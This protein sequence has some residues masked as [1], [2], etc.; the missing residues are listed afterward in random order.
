MECRNVK[1]KIYKIVMDAQEPEKEW[2]CDVL[3][4]QA[5]N[6]LGTQ[7]RAYVAVLTRELIAEGRLN[8]EVASDNTMTQVFPPKSR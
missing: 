8:G 7:D 6:M 1:E 3:S 2:H 4:E 5:L